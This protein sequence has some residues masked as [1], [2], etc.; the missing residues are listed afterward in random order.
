MKIILFNTL[1]NGDLFFTKE[2]I[3]AIVNKNPAHKFSM[4]C[5]QF[6]SLYDDIKN[7]EVIKR[8]DI[9]DFDTKPEDI[10]YHKEYYIKDYTLYINVSVSVKKEGGHIHTHCHAALN[11]CMNDHFERIIKEANALEF[12]PKLVF[13]KLTP[14][15]YTPA[16][17]DN[18]KMSDIPV[19]VRS[20]LKNPCVFYYNLNAIS[21]A[22]INSIDND[23]NIEAIANKYSGYTV[24]TA[25]PTKITLANVKALSDYNITED[26]DGKN[27]LM[28]AYIASFC[29]IVISMDTGGSQVIFNRYTLTSDIPQHIIFY[30]SEKRE[31]D[32]NKDFG[33]T[34]TKAIQKSF[35]R[36]NKHMIPLYK[37]DPET[38]LGEIEKIGPI[39][40]PNLPLEGS[41][42]RRLA[43]KSKRRTKKNRRKVV[44]RQYKKRE[45]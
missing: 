39:Q 7:L 20:I 34:I 15:E 10:D 18:M 30:L 17:L 21:V 14:V 35:T 42:G 31:S 16:V 12:K 13:D 33:I 36:D 44:K 43:Y 6:F 22:N 1:R 19:E 4:L 26:V 29:P 23:K 5:R 11:D 40:P 9:A 45:E 28:Y 3:R 32:L 2:F 24:I 41:G 27:L 38:L 25:K 37:Y 8:P